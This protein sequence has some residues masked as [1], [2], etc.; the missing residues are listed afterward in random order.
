M[1]KKVPDTMTDYNLLSRQLKAMASGESN[2]TGILANA[3]A[4]LKKEGGWFWVGFYIVSDDT[5]L[6]GPFQGPPACMR[7]PF[8]KG[9]CGAAWER[10]ETVL[11]PDVYLFPGHIACSSLSRSEIVVPVFVGGKVWGVLDIDSLDIDA[12]TSED[13]RGLELFCRTLSECL[14]G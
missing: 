12:F 5:L 8:G 1:R 3:A 2:T 13:A 14:E 11:V 4:I 9:V 6:I 7:I 10:E